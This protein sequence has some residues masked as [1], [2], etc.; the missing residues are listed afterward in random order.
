MEYDENENI[1]A[2]I[3]GIAA[4]YGVTNDKD[5]EEGEEDDE[6]YIPVVLPP[7]ISQDGLCSPTTNEV[8]VIPDKE[9]RNF[10]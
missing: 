7:R 2:H 8:I 4:D 3:I 1:V 5:E 9:P 10:G 6:D